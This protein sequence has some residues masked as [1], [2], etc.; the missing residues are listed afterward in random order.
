LDK[1]TGQWEIGGGELKTGARGG[2]FDCSIEALP[3]MSKGI[4]G[5]GKYA[6]PCLSLAERLNHGT[7][8][9]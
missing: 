5:I 4:E 6:R 9:F 7:A 3:W 2:D 8:G 1:P